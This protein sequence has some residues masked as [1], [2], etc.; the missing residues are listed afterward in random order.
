MQARSYYKFFKIKHI[1][2][3]SL[4]CSRCLSHALATFPRLQ[5]G[6]LQPEQLTEVL[7]PHGM[8]LAHDVSP[9]MLQRVADVSSSG[10][11]R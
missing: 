4:R 5:D 7:A 1:E 9:E 6:G 8:G 3:S 2:A 11:G 10:T